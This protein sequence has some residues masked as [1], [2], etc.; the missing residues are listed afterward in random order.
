MKLRQFRSSG[1]I[2]VSVSIGIAA[3]T[4]SD[5]GVWV[6]THGGGVDR[7]IGSVDEPESITFENLSQR[8]GLSNDVVYGLQ[9]DDSVLP[10]NGHPVVQWI[11]PRQSMPPL[12]KTVGSQE[13]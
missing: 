5:G 1:A 9:F 10:C 4:D 6:G 2:L 11:M 12:A 8:D 13:N 3:C 7:V